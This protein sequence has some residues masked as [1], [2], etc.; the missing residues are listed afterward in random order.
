MTQKKRKKMNLRKKEN[1]NKMDKN[2]D[3]HEEAGNTKDK[4]KNK[5]LTPKV[6]HSSMSDITQYLTPKPMKSL[7]GN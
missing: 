3:E 7:Y 2:K 6:R 1:T 5:G 4:T